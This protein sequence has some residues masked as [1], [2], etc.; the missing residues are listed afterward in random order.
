[1]EALGIEDGG[2]GEG[3]DVGVGGTEA[4]GGCSGSWQG[5]EGPDLAADAGSEE[6]SGNGLD[7][8]AC[9]GLGTTLGLAGSV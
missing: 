4:D 2:N 1:M 3:G 6:V 9:S 5:V 7:R 8:V